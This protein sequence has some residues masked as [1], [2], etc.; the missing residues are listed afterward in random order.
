MI[1]KRPL[2]IQLELLCFIHAKAVPLI[3][4]TLDGGS[5]DSCAD[6]CGFSHQT[7]FNMR[8]KLLIALSDLQEKSPTVLSGVA[9]F[10]E[11]YVLESYK[12]TKVPAEA[13]RKARKHGAKASK[14]GI[15]NEYIAICTGIQRDGGAV[16]GAANRAKPSKDEL[17]SIFEGHIAEGTLAI[18]DGLKSYSV[19]NDS[20]KC[21]VVDMN[22]SK[23]EKFYNLNTVNGLH[24]Y[25]KTAYVRYK[26]LATKYLNRYN[27]MFSLVYRCSKGLGNR[28]FASISNIG[29]LNCYHSVKDIQRSNLFTPK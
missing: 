27:A 22:Q 11:T 4:D 19:F 2:C 15:S 5:L 7:A 14:S 21:S 13:G 25:I 23:G 17:R 26:G 9:E 12:G 18:T 24:S 20:F 28:L 6:N 16:V 1:A 8:H 3:S 29:K 10:D